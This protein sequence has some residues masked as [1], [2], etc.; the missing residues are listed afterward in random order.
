MQHFY[1]FMRY[2]TQHMA[3]SRTTLSI[4]TLNNI[5]LPIKV[6]L[7]NRY[8]VYFMLSA[9]II[10]VIILNKPML[11]ALVLSVAIQPVCSASICSVKF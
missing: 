5:T 7:D 9:N 2:E 11:S 3:L 6:K 10:N 1:I 4:T 8:N